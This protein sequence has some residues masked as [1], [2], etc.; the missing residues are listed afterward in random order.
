M[1]MIMMASFGAA[2]GSIVRFIVQ[3]RFKLNAEITV[4]GINWVAAFLAGMI[5]ASELAPMLHTL[6]MAGFVGGFS[7]FSAPI[8]T[9]VDGL[10][11][12]VLRWKAVI[13]IM[14]LFIGGLVIFWFG[15]NI[16]QLLGM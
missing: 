15:Y 8:I 6:V 12:H 3:T 14:V 2:I 5:Y 7:T 16:V 9:L 4:L 1:A 11:K 13:N 10:E